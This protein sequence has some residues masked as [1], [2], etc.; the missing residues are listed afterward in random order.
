[1]YF[2]TQFTNART[3]TEL[4][5]CLNKLGLL[6]RVNSSFTL[7]TDVDTINIHFAGDPNPR[8]LRDW[9]L[10]V[11]ISP[12]QQFYFKYVTEIDVVKAIF[13]S[14]SNACGPDDILCSFLKECFPTIIAPLLHI[15]TA[16]YKLEFSQHHGNM[17]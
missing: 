4:W 15:L 11:C 16:F 6:R 7:P 5:K 2:Q 8:C 1:M 12:D 17:Q 10:T 9:R 13:A 3:T 14:R